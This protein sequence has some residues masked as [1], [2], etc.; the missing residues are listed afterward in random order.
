MAKTMTVKLNWASGLFLGIWVTSIIALF[1][2]NGPVGTHPN[3]DSANL[4]VGMILSAL[5]FV[6]VMIVSWE[7]GRGG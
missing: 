7:E 3:S 5:S 1:V 6:V 4:G 2:Y